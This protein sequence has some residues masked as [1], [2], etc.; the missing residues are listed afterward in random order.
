MPASESRVLDGLQ[1]ERAAE[2][3]RRRLDRRS[4]VDQAA[5]SGAR[6]KV[7]RYSPLVSGMQPS[8]NSAS[9]VMAARAPASV[10]QRAAGK[11]CKT[12]HAI[13]TG[14]LSLAAQ[15][16]EASVKTEMDSTNSQHILSRRVRKPVTGSR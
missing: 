16:T 2:S 7:R 1:T 11:A 9:H 4:A 10:D 15:P 6:S 8:S 13:S 5:N 14:K 12:R 3:P